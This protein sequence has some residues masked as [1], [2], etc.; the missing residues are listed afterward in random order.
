MVGHIERF[1]P[2]VQTLEKIMKSGN[3]K[4]H[5]INTSRMSMTSERITDVDVIADLMIHDL[6]IVMFLVGEAPASVVANSTSVRA[7]KDVDF[8]NALLNFDSGTIAN[9][10][11]SRI[12]QNKIRTLSVSA[13]FGYIE[14][15]YINQDL[16]IYHQ[17][18]DV[19]LGPND[20][21][22][23]DIASERVL[24]RRTEPLMLELQNFFDAISGH[25]ELKVTGAD[26][27]AVLSLVRQ[28]QSLVG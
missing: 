2:A 18:S 5:A 3:H 24:V 12:T 22:T 20:T 13:D 1:N 4:I 19:K 26:G 16:H 28:I 17:N 9:L 11:A 8:V 21:Y 6:D 23:L 14:I 15:D 10:T 27:L 25:D 7:S